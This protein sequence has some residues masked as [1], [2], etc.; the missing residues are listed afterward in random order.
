MVTF[1]VVE[2]TCVMRY[3]GFRELDEAL[4]LACVRLPVPRVKVRLGT[5]H[6]K[7]GQPVHS[8]VIAIRNGAESAMA[9]WKLIVAIPVSLRGFSHC[10]W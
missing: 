10:E 2:L 1:G 5:N 3:A 8:R 7:L 9:E 6:Q 4:H